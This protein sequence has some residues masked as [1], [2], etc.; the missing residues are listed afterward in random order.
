[1]T[2]TLHSS[3]ER[4][5]QSLSRQVA[6]GER[7]NVRERTGLSLQGT[8]DW[9]GAGIGAA[10]GGIAG[11]LLGLIGGPIGALIGLGAGVL[12][13]GVL[14]G[15]IGGAGGQQRCG[16]LLDRIR[17]H[18]VY[19]GLVG[20]ARNL[21]DEIIA[22]ARPRTNCLYYAA[23]LRLLFDTPDV[24]RAESGQAAPQG[25]NLERNRQRVND[26]V[27]QERTWRARHDPEGIL[28]G[29]QE[30]VANDPARQWTER[31]GRNGKIFY[32]DSND[33]SN[34]VVRI[35]I[36]L[37]SGGS[38]TTPQDV[39]N[40][41]FLEDAVE[42]IAETRGYTVDVVFVEEDGDDVFTFNI[43][44]D[45]YPTAANPVGN[46]RTLAH[47]IHHLMG[48]PDR[49][50][51]IEAHADNPRLPVVTRLHW[52]REQMNREPDPESA[53]SLMGSGRTMLDED[54]CRVTGMDMQ[55]C[56]EARRRSSAQR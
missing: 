23:K 15:L 13:G 55:T 44:F 29:S 4:E 30:Q 45:R 18:P 36:R 46:A 25:S 24:P 54:V 34:I 7:V 33:P 40:L 6:A 8:W 37:L 56:L 19:I 22:L 47:E 39:E 38:V 52:F 10:I 20:R 31:R 17:Q 43:D 26:A 1:L 9:Q 14:G 2:G 21:A 53:R 35:K 42:R 51:Y 32:V 11:G 41:A 3:Q 28:R 48:L 12:L 5:A 50:D 27:Q 49:Y 16:R